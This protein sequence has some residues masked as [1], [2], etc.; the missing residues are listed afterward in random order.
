LAPNSSTYEETN[1]YSIIIRLTWGERSFLFTGDAGTDSEKE[2]LDRNY[3]LKSDVLKVAHHGS[4]TSTSE[5]FLTAV[6]PEYAVISVGKD[7][8]Y[9][10]PHQVT[11][12]KLDAAGVEVLRTDLNGAITFTSDGNN[13]IVKTEK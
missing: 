6:A 12:D 4:S 13:L 7:N 9:H 5:D 3:T 8:D 11:L 2:M 10:H 1:D